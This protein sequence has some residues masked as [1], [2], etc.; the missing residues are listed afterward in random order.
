MIP[1][2]FVLQ[3][4]ERTQHGIFQ[5]DPQGHSRWHGMNGR[6]LQRSQGQWV[7]LALLLKGVI[8]TLWHLTT[9]ISYAHR[10]DL[11]RNLF[12]LTTIGGKIFPTGLRSLTHF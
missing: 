12:C 11:S 3:R 8:R 7:L 4:L 10:D 2:E 1:V 5:Q 6:S 9:L